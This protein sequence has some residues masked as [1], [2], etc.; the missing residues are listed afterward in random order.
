MKSIEQADAQAISRDLRRSKQI[1]MSR[2]LAR[3]VKHVDATPEAD[4]KRKTL[5]KDIGKWMR[6]H[7]AE[8]FSS[9]WGKD[10]KKALKKIAMALNKGG[11]FALAMPRG[12]G[13]STIVKWAVLYC[14]LTG[15]RKYVVVIAATAE[16]AQA[17]L[18]FCRH[19]IIENESL[20][21]HYPQVTTYARATEGKAIKANH[22]LRADLKP[23]GIKWSKT[24]LIFPEVI[25]PV[26]KQPYP[27]N[28]AIIEGHGLTGAIRGKWRDTKTGKVIRPD[29]VILDDPQTTESALSPA[30]CDFREQLIRGDVL[31]LAGPRKRIAAVM[32]CTIIRRG[33]L[34]DRFLDHKLHPEWQGETCGLVLK[35]PDE[36]EE[37]LWQQYREIYREE[38]GEGRG[39]EKATEFYKKNR[40]AMD[41]GAVVSWKQRVRD[42]EISALQTAENLLLETGDQFWAEYQND[43]KD[44]IAEAT[45]YTL[46]PEIVMSRTDKRRK[47]ME[48]PEWV[49]RVLASTDVNPSYA[50]STVVLGFGEDQSAVVIWYGLHKLT[51]SGDIPSAVLARALY[52]SLVTHGKERA[53]CGLKIEEWAIDAGGGQ[54]DP[55]I[56]FAGDA[57]R[58]CGIPAHGFTGRGASKYR[59]W[60]KNVSGALREE[61]HGCMA[62][63][64]GRT[65]R[66]VAWNADY[67]K[68]A[69]QRAW[70]GEIGSP[71]SISLYEGSHR[72]FATQVCADKLMGK[73]EVGGQMMWNFHRVPGRND[74][75]DAM[76]QGYALAAYMGIGTHGKVEMRGGRKKYRQSDLTR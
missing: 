53:N 70:L 73:G 57:A 60:G 41:K 42:N 64:D 23:S 8:A 29:F 10:H 2:I 24:T 5:E 63:K 72:E 67:W 40:K 7:G 61:C 22:Q 37:G 20:H 17:I 12:G 59:P 44:P 30:Q 54:F 74:F 71:G 25:S 19:Q 18:D 11:L 47:A 14:M 35:W 32:P 51:I 68:E 75:G 34:A 39:F 21:E 1:T 43:P 31:G 38:T 3:V 62:K 65:I 26:T 66:W 56:R 48:R 55:V 15:R 9:P 16:M 13:K 6:Y 27:S 76:A 33:D 36:H 4:E 58:L 49:T 28:G 69:A 46:T 52:E 50:F 45:P